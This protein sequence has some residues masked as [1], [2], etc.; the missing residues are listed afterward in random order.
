MSSACRSDIVP[1]LV[2]NVTDPTQG[3]ASATLSGVTQ[4]ACA[5]N[6]RAP[7]EIL[8]DGDV[9]VGGHESTG[10]GAGLLEQTPLMKAR[11]WRSTTIR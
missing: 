10:D 3:C 11:S 6:K 4:P 2:R 1:A 5:D 8:K 9:R 7:K